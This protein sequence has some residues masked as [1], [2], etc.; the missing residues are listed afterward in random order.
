MGIS[1]SEI[2]RRKLIEEQNTLL[3][4]KTN[5]SNDT[6]EGKIENARYMINRYYRDN[7]ILAIDKSSSKFL[8]KNVLTNE[9]EKMMNATTRDDDDSTTYYDK[10]TLESVKKLI[11][12][13]DKLYTLEV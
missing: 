12:K 9:I 3:S 2:A 7:N 4:N 10:K 11:E 5:Y 13:L 8:P 6:V 1:A